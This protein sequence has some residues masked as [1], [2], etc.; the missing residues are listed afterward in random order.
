M[1]ELENFIYLCNFNILN[2]IDMSKRMLFLCILLICSTISRSQDTLFLSENF[3]VDM[4]DTLEISPNT[5]VYMRGGVAFT[6][7][8]TIYARGTAEEPIIFTSS[9]DEQD[10]TSTSWRGFKFSMTD[11][12][13]I[14]DSSI[15]EHCIFE[16]A[17]AYQNCS[18]NGQG[19]A[20]ELENSSRIRFSNCT[21]R[22]NYSNYC[23]AAVYAINSNCIFDHCLF[24]DNVLNEETSSV[25]GALY[26]QASDFT[27]TNSAV[28]SSR[29]GSVGGGICCMYCD[30]AKIIN[31]EIAYNIGSTGGGCFIYGSSNMLFV[32]NLIHHNTGSFFGG[33]L[34]LSNDSFKIINCNIVDNNAG[35]GG[36]VYCS[37]KVTINVYNTIFAKNSIHEGANGPQI[38]IAYFEST[39]NLFN[40]VLEQG[41][42]MVG[43]GGGGVAF[44]GI[45]SEII[46]DEI[47]FVSCGNDFEYCLNENSPCVNAGSSKTNAELPAYDINGTQRI[48]DN[49]VDI[50]AFEYDNSVGITNYTSNNQTI[51]VFPNPAS[52]FITVEVENDDRIQHDIVIVSILGNTVKKTSCYNDCNT[53]SINDL[54][55]GVYILRYDTKVAKFVVSH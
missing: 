26:M 51:K 45:Y 55:N 6:I 19:G 39:T 2:K 28:K 49:I 23:G 30:A 40:C 4:G 33:G 52:E 15:F 32:N 47:E 46:E 36:G 17:H 24:E 53:I 14:A 7:I 37:S 27:M 25:G 18:N 10:P 11:D 9:F 8:G 43:G 48:L 16:H 1:S 3:V 42:Y 13:T 31:S 22:D 29:S 44:H 38:Y 20:M 54:A 50:G 35:Q 12:N 5:V 21:F 41:R 34:G